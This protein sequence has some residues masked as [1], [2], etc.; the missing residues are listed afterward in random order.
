MEGKITLEKIIGENVYFEV[1]P[2]P[3]EYI[4]KLKYAGELK[5]DLSDEK[6]LTEMRLEIL[7]TASAEFDK[8]KNNVLL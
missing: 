2:V 7:K 1:E 4:D 8:Y 6:K 5:G 3:A